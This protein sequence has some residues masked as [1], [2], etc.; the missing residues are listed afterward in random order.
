M[1]GAEIFHKKNNH[2]GCFVELV[3]IFFG[4]PRNN[5]GKGDPM[6]NWTFY[7]Q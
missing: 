3:S 7:N 2:Q 6:E 4:I 1:S 5:L